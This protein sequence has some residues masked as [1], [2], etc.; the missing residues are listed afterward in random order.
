MTGIN[1]SP[2]EIDIIPCFS[3]DR[4]KPAQFLEHLG[5]E[6]HVA[7]RNVLRLAVREHDVQ[8]IPW[9]IGDTGGD[10]AIPGRGNVGPAHA[11]VL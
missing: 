7:A 2:A 4:I 1:E 11:H 9:R 8:R 5:A 3:E 6:G 10:G